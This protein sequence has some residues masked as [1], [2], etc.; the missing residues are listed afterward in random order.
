MLLA[1]YLGTLFYGQLQKKLPE[2]ADP[3]T[4]AQARKRRNARRTNSRI[5]LVCIMVLELVL[6]LVNF[7][8]TVSFTTVKNYPKG[9]DNTASVL[10]YVK[11]REDELFYRVEMTHAQTLNDDALNGYSG[12]SAFTSSANVRV[13]EFMK[14]LGYGAKNTY[15]RYCWEEA[16][17]VSNLFLNLKYLIDRDDRDR[18]S[19]VF[20]ELYSYGSIHLLEN[21]AWLPLGFLADTGLADVAFDTGSGVF[22][23][24]NELFS[25]ATG[26][27]ADVWHKLS[28][29]ALTISA[30]NV[31]IKDQSGSG[32]CSYS[33]AGSKA[34]IVYAYTADREGFLCVNV[35][36]PKRNDVT[37][38]VNG[39]VIYTETTSLAQMMAVSDVT[40]GDVVEVE[41]ACDEGES[42]TMTLTAAI[43][44]M[45][46]FWEGYEILNASTL[47]LTEFSNTLVE[48]IIECDRDGLLYTSVPQ[49]GYWTVLVDGEEA[50]IALVGECMIAVELDAGVHEITFVYRNPAFSLGWKISL[51]CLLVFGILVMLVYKPHRQPPKPLKKKTRTKGKYEK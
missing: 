20:T 44:D 48:G 38:R 22:A 50:Q 35:D 34:T 6:N 23:F 28:S 46:L 40:V 49:N 30:N 37:I 7:G 26:L 4:L 36:L 10:R 39:N 15:N 45:D 13:T 14:A 18:S 19:S 16:S 17:P 9:T 47:E 51:G 21:D 8:T 25:G 42:G 5:V 1:L 11:E 2:D 3:K 24:Q 12:V 32:Y 33:G 29:A 41:M 27:D 31:T 43:L